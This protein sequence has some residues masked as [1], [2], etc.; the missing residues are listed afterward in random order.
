MKTIIITEEQLQVIV[1]SEKMKKF[2]HNKNKTAKKTS[3]FGYCKT[4]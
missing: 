1:E 4:F 3:R 2:K